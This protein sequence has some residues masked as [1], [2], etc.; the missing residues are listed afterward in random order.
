MEPTTDLN[1]QASFA[2]AQQRMS[3]IG[4]ETV[5]RAHGIHKSFGGEVVLDEVSLELHRGEVVLLR[6][7]NGSGKTTLLNIL[8][9]NIEPDAG[10]IR[11]FS[12]GE[13]RGFHFPGHWWRNFNP[14]NDFTPERLSE[15]GVGRTWQDVRLFHSQ[16][17]RDNVA[18]ATPKQKGENPFWAIVRRKAVNGQERK[19]LDDCNRILTDFGLSGRETSYADK[20]SLG[21]SKRVAI[22]RALQAGAHIIFLDEP[23]AGLD[24]IGVTGILEL[25]GKLA[26]DEKVTLVIVEHVFN[27]PRVLK[28]ATTLWTLA[29]GKLHI[30]PTNDNKKGVRPY[31]GHSYQDLLATLGGPSNRIKHRVLSRGAVLSTISRD[32]ALGGATLEVKDL[33]VYRGKRLV[34]GEEV[35][36]GEPK[37]LSFILQKGQM[38]V[39]QAPNGWGKT[40][41]VEAIAGLIPVA[42]GEVRLNGQSLPLSRPWE[43]ARYGISLLQA[44]NNTFPTLTVK[45][46]LRLARVRTVPQSI[47]H[48]LGR[49][50]SDLSGGERQKVAIACLQ[51][52]PSNVLV[53]DEPFSSLDSAGIEVFQQTFMSEGSISLLLAIPS[54]LIEGEPE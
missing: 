11:L 30:S 3:R 34:I 43:I 27:I 42:R 45:E 18:V 26:K 8:S 5:L 4:Q 36:T 51:G 12:H 35:H 31:T 16:N 37:G 29:N 39:L 17:L 7:D 19:I 33:V 32:R 20:V 48:F 23:L 50:I 47:R 44:K 9:G 28:L 25:L 40:T 10:I 15:E 14:F 53:L 22:A 38:C 41:L 54:F 6:G 21:Q 1:S 52:R 2:S 46:T 49:R 13:Q 24:S